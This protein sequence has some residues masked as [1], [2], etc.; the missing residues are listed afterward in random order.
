MAEFVAKRVKNQKLPK[1]R[2]QE[3]NKKSR[4]QA[5]LIEAQTRDNYSKNLT[6]HRKTGHKKATADS[7]KRIGGLWCTQQDSNLWPFDS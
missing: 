2:L 5:S 7:A 3:Y 4:A 1:N 6:I